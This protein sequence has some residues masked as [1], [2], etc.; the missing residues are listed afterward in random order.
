MHQTLIL[1]RLLIFGGALFFC[2]YVFYMEKYK[3]VDPFYY[4]KAT[5]NSETIEKA[6][7]AGERWGLDIG[8]IFLSFV[9][10][11][12]V[13]NNYIFMG[14]F[15]FLCVLFLMC[16]WNETSSPYFILL[17]LMLVLNSTFFGYFFNVWRQGVA[18]FLILLA[19]QYDKKKLYLAAITFH[20]NSALILAAPLLFI[21]KIKKM[22]LAMIVVLIL[23]GLLALLIVLKT[24][25]FFQEAVD[26]YSSTTT[27]MAGLRVLYGFFSFLLVWIAFD[28]VKSKGMVISENAYF[29][30][31]L[32]ILSISSLFA[33]TMPAAS[34]R[35]MHYFMV[36]FPFYVFELV[37]SN[38]LL[39]RVVGVSAS[40]V[41]ITISSYFLFHSETWDRLIFTN[42]IY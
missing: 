23:M 27:K 32:I 25:S 18:S 40:I 16:V 19:F 1:N 42:W 12:F 29:Y 30:P 21:E 31:C 13:S 24:A 5:E 20:F 9:I 22:S 6:I 15:I 36:F 4:I 34:E 3:L 28:K 26:I 35:Y 37:K 10:N 33:I 14:F 8:F 38:E 7:D 2:L 17:I 41:H 11:F 39:V